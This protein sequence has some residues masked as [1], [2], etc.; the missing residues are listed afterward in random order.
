M[1]FDFIDKVPQ[2]LSHQEPILISGLDT[3]EFGGREY[4]VIDNNEKSLFEI[5]Y[6]Y[7]GSPFKQAFIIDTILAVGYE[8]NFY[9]FDL[10]TKTNILKMKMEGYFGHF[11]LNNDNFYVADA[12]GLY[13]IDKLGTTLWSNN[14]LGI[15]GV[16]INDFVDNKIL[17]SGEWDPP[18]GW[19]DF[20]L[21]KQTGTS[22]E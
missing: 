8:E 3:L 4:L 19:R 13:C 10:L 22:I 11:Y 1:T 2:D 6:E 21:D 16:I 12:G 9:L 7:H 18:G 20:I 15:D 17:G 5:R 14:N